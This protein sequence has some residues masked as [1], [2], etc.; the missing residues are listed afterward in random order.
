[1]SAQKDLKQ[2]MFIRCEKVIYCVDN[3]PGN[4]GKKT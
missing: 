4:C 2:M 1:M 3:D